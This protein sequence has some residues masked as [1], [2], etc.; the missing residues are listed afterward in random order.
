MTAPKVVSALPSGRAFYVKW[1]MLEDRLDPEYYHPKH[2]LLSQRMRASGNRVATLRELSKRV[3]DGPF[4]SA[5]KAS[6]YAESGVPFLRVADVTRGEGII[7]TVDLAFITQDAHERISRSK[8]QYGDLV[9]AKT[10][11]TM[12]AASLVPEGFPEANIRADLAAITLLDPDLSQYLVNYINTGIGRQLFWR[13][14]SGA[15]RGRVVIQNLLKYPV[16]LPAPQV[17]NQVDE[18]MREARLKKKRMEEEATTLLN[19]ADDILLSELGIPRTPEPRSA[20]AG[21]I[22]C[23]AFSHVTG[24]RFDPHYHRPEF[25]QLESVLVA[26]KHARLG[27]VVS[28][29]RELWDQQSLFLDEFPYVEIGDVDL[30]LGRMNCSHFL[31]QAWLEVRGCV[32]PF[33]R[34]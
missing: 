24:G 10:G 28:L 5:I 17:R 7:A 3:V 6:D 20:I 8:V 4:G 32:S 12:G 15:T 31:S 34:C 33:S 25:Q 11:A 26:S 27:E 30:V 9:I 2:Y 18:A 14:N 1:S 13:L 21:R 16:V 22:F 19:G 23:R 29:S